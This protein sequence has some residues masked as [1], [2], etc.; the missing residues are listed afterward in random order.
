MDVFGAD[1]LP[2]ASVTL[3]NGCFAWTADMRDNPMPQMVQA[4]KLGHASG[5]PHAGG[6]SGARPNA[7]TPMRAILWPLIWAS[8][9]G[10]VCAFWA[11]LH[12]Y[13]IYGA[14][15]AKVRPWLATMGLQQANQT[16][17]LLASRTPRD[18]AGFAAA[19][20]GLAIVVACSALRLRFPWWPIHPLGYALATT[21]SL[22]YMWCP[23]FIAW[24][25]K[26]L[27]VRYGGI[28]AYRAALPFFLGLTLGDYVVPTLWGV[29]GMITGQQQYMAFPH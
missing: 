5:E 8:L 10:T 1:R 7:G 23:F 24:L 20:G 3:L 17:N 15:T 2:P 18:S 13:Y 11:H 29:W 28:K 9:F 21:N 27:T 26:T 19:G 6:H 4:M 22:D 14:A 25:A 12:V 16:A